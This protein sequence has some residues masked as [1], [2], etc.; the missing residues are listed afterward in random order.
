MYTRVGIYTGQFTGSSWLH[1][2]W[3]LLVLLLLNTSTVQ[4]QAPSGRVEEIR[5]LYPSEWNVPYPAGLAYSAKF[6]RL[7]LIDKGN[8]ET[9]PRTR[10]AIVIITPYEDLVATMQLAFT[11]DDAIHI[12]YDDANSHL[13]LLNEKRA[14]LTRVALD[15]DGLSA[16]NTIRFDIAHLKL[17]SASGIDVDQASRRLFIVDNEAAQV[18]SASL[19]DFELIAKI[20]LAHLGA[21]TLR[22]IAVH[23]RN[24]HL[25]LM[26][27]HEKTLYELTQSGTLV[28]RYDLTDLNLVDPGGVAFAPSADLTDA[29]ETIHLYIVDSNWPDAEQAGSGGLSWM[30]H[31]PA[32]AQ[33]YS[34]VRA[35]AGETAPL[36]GRVLE[37]ALVPGAGA[38]DRC[39]L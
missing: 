2:L 38:S 29:P 18:V 17:Q 22:G 20:D 28:N 25:Y 19:D 13:L 5:T 4:A 36:F 10:S 16:R 37:V 23:P 35:A 1:G 7:F 32:S 11:L 8:P 15:E 21:S 12:A 27:P 3:L 9:L 6:D 14:Q 31:R 39:S 30:H 33:S 26:A 34:P 24:H